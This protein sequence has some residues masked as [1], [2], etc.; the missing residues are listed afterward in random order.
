MTS[1]NILLMTV[2]QC[3][4]GTKPVPLIA[5]VSF[6]EAE[7]AEHVVYNVVLAAL[8]NDTSDSKHAAMKAPEK[9]VAHNTLVL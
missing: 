2:E 8:P 7:M 1:S 3:L 6:K 4:K 9:K 5:L